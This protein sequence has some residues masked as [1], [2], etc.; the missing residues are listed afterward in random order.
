MKIEVYSNHQ[1][2]GQGG[3]T[4]RVQTFDFSAP[5]KSVVWKIYFATKDKFNLVSHF[6]DREISG[7]HPNLN[8]LGSRSYLNKSRTKRNSRG[9]MH[10]K[11]SQGPVYVYYMEIKYSCVIIHVMIMWQAPVGRFCKCTGWLYEFHTV[12]MM[13]T[14]TVS[15][16]VLYILGT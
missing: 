7:H 9:N 6:H 5:S 8:V 13:C 1:P 11:R 14:F 15:V 16:F 3:T 4:I 2:Q 10:I 12:I